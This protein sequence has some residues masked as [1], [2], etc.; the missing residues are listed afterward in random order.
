[1]EEEKECIECKRKLPLY[2]YE[3]YKKQVFSKKDN[4]TYEKLYIRNKCKSCRKGEEVLPRQIRASR[5]LPKAQKLWE[6]HLRQHYGITPEDYNN[7]LKSQDGKC[8]ICK[9]S[10]KLHLDHCHSTGKVRGI[11]CQSCNHGLGNFKDN[12]DL[13]KKG[14]EYLSTFVS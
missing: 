13:M 3:P 6:Y 4:R 12:L 7:I 10:N 2:Q 11:L 5:R 8:K 1:M 14:I 9:S